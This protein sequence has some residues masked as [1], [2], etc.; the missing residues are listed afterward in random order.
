MPEQVLDAVKKKLYAEIIA[1]DPGGLAPDIVA[2]VDSTRKQGAS[3]IQ[4]TNI[5]GDL[6]KYTEASIKLATI[7]LRSNYIFYAY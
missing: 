1:T 4:V 2:R 7:I 5:I 6:S 3:F